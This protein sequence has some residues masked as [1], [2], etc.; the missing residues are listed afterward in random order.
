MK[1]FLAIEKKIPQHI[2]T[3]LSL[4][5]DKFDC[6][7]LMLDISI[8]SFDIYFFNFMWYTEHRFVICYNSRNLAL[9][10]N[11]FLHSQFMYFFSLSLLLLLSCKCIFQLFNLELIY[12]FIGQTG[13]YY[14]FQ[15]GKAGKSIEIGDENEIVL[16]FL[17]LD[18]LPCLHIWVTDIISFYE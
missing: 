8:F 1:Q 2:S 4:L 9:I 6:V 3:F 7:L 13:Q 10:K 12:A 5:Q 17:W 14:S 16:K 15:V 11:I 18:T